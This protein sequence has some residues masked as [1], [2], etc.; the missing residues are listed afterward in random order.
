M[1]STLLLFLGKYDPNVTLFF[2]SVSTVSL[3]SLHQAR[4]FG[5]YYILSST[6]FGA[7]LHPESHLFGTLPF[8]IY[9][10]HALFCL[11]IHDFSMFSKCFTLFFTLPPVLALNHLVPWNALTWVVYT[12]FSSQFPRVVNII[13]ITRWN[14]PFQAT[15]TSLFKI[16]QLYFIGYKGMCL[17][18]KVKEMQVLPDSNNVRW[19]WD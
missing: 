7:P 5:L 11:Y 19:N 4:S 1:L 15:T 9:A 12:K 8:F 16:A 14:D 3:V 18:H 17:C 10:L 13:Y 2:N 6:P